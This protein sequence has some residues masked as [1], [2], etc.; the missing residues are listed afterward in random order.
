MM[1]LI[2]PLAGKPELVANREVHAPSLGGG[3]D[4]TAILQRDGHGLFEEEMLAL[5][6]GGEGDLTMRVAGGD[7][8]EDVEVSLS[9][10]L[11]AVG[12]NLGLG[13]KLAGELTRGLRRSANGDELGL[14]MASDGLGVKA[15][16]GPKAGQGKANG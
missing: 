6:D 3:D 2:S 8:V 12:K 5:F 11:K 9:D 10:E 1:F 4:G 14:G 13:I 15:A 16:P 7:D